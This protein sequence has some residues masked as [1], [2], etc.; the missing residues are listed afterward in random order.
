MYKRIL[1]VQDLSCLGHCSGA[2]ALPVLSAWGHETCLLP[3]A[4]LSTHTGFRDPYIRHLTDSTEKIA[5]HWRRQ[6]I[7]F[8]GIL[9]GYLGSRADVQHVCDIMDMGGI[10]IVDPAMA[11]H[12]RL[13][14]GLEEDYVEA[15]KDLCR[16]ADILLPNV[17]EAAI[18]TGQPV[19]ETMTEETAARLLRALPNEKAVLTGAIQE[20]ADTGVAVKDGENITF[21]RH[22]KVPGAFSG[23]GDLYAAC[24]A[25]AL[26]GGSSL[27]D[28]AAFAASFTGNCVRETAKDPGRSYG[29]KF[30]PLLGKIT[31][32]VGEWQ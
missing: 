17:T 10:C 22:E 9:T 18:L 24:F 15:M 20:P 27:L 11:D 6:G 7:L 30:E 1:T 21:F 32:K 29:V 19:P 31:Q 25:G 26:L 13:Y 3:T 2:V 23:T 12:G 16:K 5:D 4:L 8:D 28:A 14:K